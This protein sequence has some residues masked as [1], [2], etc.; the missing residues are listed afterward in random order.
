MLP[1]VSLTFTSNEPARGPTFRCSSW[2][3]RP[4]CCQVAFKRPSWLFCTCTSRT[5]RDLKSRTSLC[6]S[7]TVHY[8]VSH[9]PLLVF[10][11]HIC[12]SLLQCRALPCI[13]QDHAPALYGPCH[14]TR[15][16]SFSVV[17]CAQDLPSSEF[18][19]LPIA[20][21]PHTQVWVPHTADWLGDRLH[22]CVPRDRLCGG[23]P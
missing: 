22:P 19:V 23:K 9:A 4:R 13:V 2:L 3:L 20:A 17:S 16:P 6:R 1:L 5:L 14:I 15:W 21:Q 7:S 11:P 8:M 18:L 12:P 10:L